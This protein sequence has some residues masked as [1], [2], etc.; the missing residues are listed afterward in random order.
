MK[1]I[2]TLFL[3]LFILS[4]AAFSQSF[5]SR[6]SLKLPAVIFSFGHRYDDAYSISSYERDMQISKI[7]ASYNEQVK[8]VMN[9]R[10]AAPKKVDLIQQLQ[11]ERNNKIQNVNDRFFDYRNKYN[12]NHYDQHFNWIK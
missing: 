7:K 4:S 2:F 3:T 1:K 12:Y 11:K 8:E 10:I 5:I 9:L 6:V